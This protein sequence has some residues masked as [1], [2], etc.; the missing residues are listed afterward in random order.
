MG[1]GR[2]CQRVA[3]YV[4]GHEK[5]NDIQYSKYQKTP[6]NPTMLKAINA[7]SLSYCSS[8]RVEKVLS[9]DF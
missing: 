3:L 4:H 5:V 6:P 1:F 2:R 7:N 9:T 8:L